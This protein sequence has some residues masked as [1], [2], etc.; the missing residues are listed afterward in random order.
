M[1]RVLKS[2]GLSLGLFA[3]LGVAAC[4][5]PPSAEG[6]GATE[7]A[8]TATKL[9][10]VKGREYARCWFD[11]V[12]KNAQLSCTSTKRGDDPLGSTVEVA[13]GGNGDM[14]QSLDTINGGTVVVASFPLE[15]FPRDVNL[16]ATFDDRVAKAIGISRNELVVERTHVVPADLQRSKALVLVQPF[17]LWPIA[18]VS[19][20]AGST[21]SATAYAGKDAAESL[22]FT[23]DLSFSG[24]T[25][26]WVVAPPSGAI[27]ATGTVDGKA[28]TTSIPGPGRY[29]L[30]ASGLHD[31]DQ[32][33]PVVAPA[34]HPS[35]STTTDAT[36]DPHPDC[37]GDKQSAC[38]DTHSCDPGTRLEPFSNQCISCGADGQPYCFVDPSGTSMS[39]G[40]KCNPGTRL[41][42][43]SNRCMSCGGEG[44]T[45]CYADPNGVSFSAGNRCNAGLRL[46]A[47]SSQCER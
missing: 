28:I 32:P 10:A 34:Q 25:V 23:P 33:P 11:V 12:G 38:A 5:V 19:R 40:T 18:I 22:K 41:D 29:A 17:D 9:T 36:T 8:V 20:T 42:S 6:E 30:D 15:T 44:Q 35:D 4:A 46:A 31:P 24:D 14:T 39:Q 1:E 45:Y 27:A 16:T 47:G 21:L 37:G 26:H 2:L 43:F 3:L 13:V 7:D